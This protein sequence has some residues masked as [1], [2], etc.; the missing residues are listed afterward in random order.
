MA[1][2]IKLW[3]VAHDG[4]EV[5]AAFPDTKQ[6]MNFIKLKFLDDVQYI[7]MLGSP[8]AAAIAND[9]TLDS[10]PR[11]SDFSCITVNGM[12]ILFDPKE[13]LMTE[14][15]SLSAVIDKDWVISEFKEIYGDIDMEKVLLSLLPSVPKIQRVAEKKLI[16][17]EGLV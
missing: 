15:I 6:L 2:K 12:A 17:P 9:Q 11:L 10:D 16:I 3:F 1:E 4:K 5:V 8:A 7:F 13:E 14:E